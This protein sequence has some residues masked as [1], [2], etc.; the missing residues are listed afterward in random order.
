MAI[1]VMRFNP[2]TMAQ[3]S[4]GY[5][6]LQNLQQ[7][8]MQ[9]LKMQQMAEQQ[10]LAEQKAAQEARTAER[11]AWLRARRAQLTPAARRKLRAAPY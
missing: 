3:A 7:G 6:G 2:L 4:P 5:F 11:V 8:L 1:G 10:K 9:G